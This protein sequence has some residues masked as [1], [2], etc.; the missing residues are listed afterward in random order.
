M[1]G[2][3]KETRARPAHHPTQAK[4]V[5][6]LNQPLGPWQRAVGISLA[7]IRLAVPPRAGP[8]LPTATGGGRVH[9]QSVTLSPGRQALVEVC[10]T[11]RGLPRA[12]HRSLAQWHEPGGL[13][14]GLGW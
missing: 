14:Q 4:V 12:S 11:L 5:S 1:V 8:D 3:G 13:P 2:R 7:T 6:P 10:G 9:P